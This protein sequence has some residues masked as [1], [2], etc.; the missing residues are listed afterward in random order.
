M[1]NSA[2][3]ED[4]NRNYDPT[5]EFS[6]NR[7]DAEDIIRTL[8]D[9]ETLV[10][11]DLED[12]GFSETMSPDRAATYFSDAITN[13]QDEHYEGDLPETGE[14]G[15]SVEG[16]VSNGSAA[17][18]APINVTVSMDEP[19]EYGSGSGYIVDV[20]TNHNGEEG[21]LS[22]TSASIEGRPSNPSDFGRLAEENPG[23]IGDTYQAIRGNLNH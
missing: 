6:V 18:L 1:T 13:G 17:K 10:S 15:R 12:D 8:T 11:V 7:K 4:G 16:M 21:V 22:V 5:Q 23:D 9:G 14:L 2:W 20:D 3:T 19:G